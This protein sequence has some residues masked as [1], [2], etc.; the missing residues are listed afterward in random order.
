MYKIQKKELKEYLCGLVHQHLISLQDVHACGIFSEF[1]S[2]LQY[3]GKCSLL[4]AMLSLGSQSRV[5]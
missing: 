5:Q 1:E 4:R 3:W 2:T